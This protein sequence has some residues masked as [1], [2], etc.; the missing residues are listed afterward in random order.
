MIDLSK[1]ASGD[2]ELQVF[3]K[4]EVIFEADAP[5]NGTMYI[6][7]VG[8]VDVYK[9]YGQQGEICVATLV[10]SDFFGEMSLFLDK[11]RTA[12]VVVREDAS[13]LVIDQEGMLEFLKKQPELAFSFMQTLC[14]RLENTNTSAAQNRLSYEQDVSSLITEN[15]KMD[16]I[17]NLDPLT[18]VYNRRYFRDVAKLLIDA[19]ASQGK[20]SYISIFDLDHFKKVND[21]HG[22]DAG[23]HVLITFAKMVNGAIRADDLF[24]R[25]GGEEFIMLIS[26]ETNEEA[27]AAFERVRKKTCAKP[28]VFRETEIPV[29]T[30]IGVAPLTSGSQLDSAITLADEA[31]Y[32]A[33]ASGRNRT[34]MSS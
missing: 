24:A 26:A 28:I 11:K 23:D 6:L 2:V 1:L 4:G 20:T 27:F 9:N 30:S 16:T 33:K 12:T 25:Y 19:S 3:K 15:S 34:I 32:E 5:S 10:A 29:T 13:V 31:L 14:T 7:F 8:E 18:G 21:T 22:H 17:L